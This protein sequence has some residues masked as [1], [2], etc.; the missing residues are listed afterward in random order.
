MYFPLKAH[1]GARTKVNMFLR[2][3]C[4][5]VVHY[6]LLTRPEVMQIFTILSMCSRR[7]N[8]DDV[9]AHLHTL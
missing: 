9:C 5:D 4:H 2:D 3:V 1:A 6:G 8:N 7:V